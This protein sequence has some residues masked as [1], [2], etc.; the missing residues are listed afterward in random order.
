MVKLISKMSE[1]APSVWN[2]A[3]QMP[4]QMERM[5]SVTEWCREMPSETENVC[6]SNKERNHEHPDFERLIIN[7]Q[8]L[9]V[10]M[11]SN[12][13][14]SHYPF[15]VGKNECWRYTAYRQYTMWVWGHLGKGNRKVIPSCI[16][17]CIR[18]RY[19]D[20][21]NNYTGFMDANYNL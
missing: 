20:S 5:D 8:T 10:A 16:L 11:R 19:P 14:W 2:Q 15:D 21:S 12:C 4:S 6:C 13:D 18:D 9:E 3:I 7:D 1:L 17:W